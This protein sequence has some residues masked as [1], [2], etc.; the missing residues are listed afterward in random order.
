MPTRAAPHLAAVCAPAAPRLASRHP[1][2]LNSALGRCVSYGDVQFSFSAR[3]V[4][5]AMEK[6]AVRPSSEPTP[7]LCQQD[8]RKH[9]AYWINERWNIHVSHT[10]DARTS[11]P[12]I[13]ATGPSICWHSAALDE[14][15]SFSKRSFLQCEARRRLCHKMVSMPLE[16]CRRS[17]LALRSG[18]P[19]QVAVLCFASLTSTFKS[20]SP[21]Q[22]L[23]CCQLARQLGGDFV[24]GVAWGNEPTTGAAD[25]ETATTARMQ[26]VYFCLC[27][28]GGTCSRNLQ[29]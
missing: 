8:M 13:T 5:M 28:F 14:R 19:N 7:A 11:N 23:T 29:D 10:I 20:N 15:Q 22:C 25:S 12:T 21:Y 9:L 16:L 26:G 1:S 24:S 17:L 3:E 6:L 2:Q 27:H 18:S 4:L